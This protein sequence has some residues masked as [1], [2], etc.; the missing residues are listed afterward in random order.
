MGTFFGKKVR[1][2]HKGP[3]E[4]NNFQIMLKDNM[5]SVGEKEGTSATITDRC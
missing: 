5:V 2:T 3:R 4:R 1:R